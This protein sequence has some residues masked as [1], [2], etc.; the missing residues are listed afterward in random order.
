[1][2][3]PPPGFIVSVFQRFAQHRI[4]ARLRVQWWEVVRHDCG[5]PSLCSQKY[6]N[7]RGGSGCLLS[8]REPASLRELSRGSS[9]G[10]SLELARSMWLQDLEERGGKS[11]A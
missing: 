1:M 4:S 10:R 5:E 7:G 6:V 9:C 3:L 11:V 2:V 8:G